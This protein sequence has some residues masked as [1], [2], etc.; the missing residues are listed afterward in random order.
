MA[1]W[2]SG[3]YCSRERSLQREA[4]AVVGVCIGGTWLRLQSNRP[5]NRPSH[6]RSD[7]FE[8]AS[9]RDRR[10]RVYAKET[11]YRGAARENWR[12]LH[13]NCDIF[14]PLY[15]AAPFTCGNETEGSERLSRRLQCLKSMGPY[16]PA[17]VRRVRWSFVDEE[18]PRGR[19]DFRS[20][21]RL[22]TMPGKKSRAASTKT[23]TP[24]I[25]E[26][27]DYT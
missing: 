16:A 14:P 9:I 5:C 6:H 15:S 10:V 21:L 27:N 26:R 18:K 17:V 25:I 12:R 19:V 11:P 23:A 8:T 1:G 7:Y 3:A 24:K 2:R 13:Y 20:E 4:P 22:M